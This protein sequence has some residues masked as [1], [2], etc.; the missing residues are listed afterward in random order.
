MVRVEYTD[1][2]AQ[3]WMKEDIVPQFLSAI[4][5][6]PAQLCRVLGTTC[7]PLRAPTQICAW[8]EPRT[9]TKNNGNAFKKRKKGRGIIWWRKLNDEMY[10]LRV[11]QKDDRG[12]HS[13]R[14]EERAALNQNTTVDWIILY[15]L[16]KDG[17]RPFG[18]CFSVD[19]IRGG[20]SALQQQ[21]NVL[22]C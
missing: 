3:K 14:L 5:R 12:R 18:D 19:Y 8:E 13:L 9:E 17:N 21:I 6:T 11:I 10:T 20:W 15:L 16:C 7:P 1:G 2:G 22:F 4:P